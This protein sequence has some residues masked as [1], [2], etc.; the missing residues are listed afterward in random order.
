MRRRDFFIGVVGSAA[1]W[2]L[3]ARAQEPAIPVVGFLR[4]TPATP[5]VHLVAALRQG[6]NEEGFAEGRNVAIEQHWADNDPGRLGGSQ[7]IWSVAKWL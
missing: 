2:P 1:T 4:S 5:F 3:A 6:L 7:P